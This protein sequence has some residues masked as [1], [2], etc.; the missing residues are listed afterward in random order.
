MKNQLGQNENKYQIYKKKRRKMVLQFREK[1]AKV[2]DG[3][4]RLRKA[5]CVKNVRKKNGKVGDS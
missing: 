2:E 1:N 3:F 4:L 5:Q